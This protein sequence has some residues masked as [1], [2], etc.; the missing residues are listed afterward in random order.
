MRLS[1]A[2]TSGRRHVLNDRSADLE[3]ISRASTHTRIHLGDRATSPRCSFC[4]HLGKFGWK[5]HL[6]G[7]DAQG[8]RPRLGTGGWDEWTL[9]R[10]QRGAAGAEAGLASRAP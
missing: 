6:H 2:G 5:L 1:P 3:R 7:F 8:H 10:F 9:K 4:M